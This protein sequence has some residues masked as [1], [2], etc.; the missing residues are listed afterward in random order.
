[1]AKIWI[2]DDKLI[3]DM[4]YSDN[5]TEVDLG[6]FL[7]KYKYEEDSVRPKYGLLHYAVL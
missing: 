1:M 5:H 7:A 6:I 4:Y 2:Y 3:V